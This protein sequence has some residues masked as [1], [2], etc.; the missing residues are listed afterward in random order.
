MVTEIAEIEVKVGSEE[1]FIAGVEACKPVFERAPGFH[2]IELHRSI[3][4][5]QNFLLMIKW[6][7]VAHHMEMFQKSPDFAVWRATVGDCFA[8]RPKL[9]HTETVVSG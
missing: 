6:E 5:P 7:S 9:Q 3:E 2:G 8:G 1:K 4:H